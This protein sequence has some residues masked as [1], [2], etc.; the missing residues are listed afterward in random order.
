MRTLSERLGP[1]PKVTQR[2]SIGTTTNP[3]GSGPEPVPGPVPWQRSGCSGGCRIREV[4]AAPG[5]K[6]TYPPIPRPAPAPSILTPT[7]IPS[8]RTIKS[9]F[10]REREPL[11][12]TVL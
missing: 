9:A 10:R 12:H 4:A 5:K 8:P 2:A 6:R 11:P 3:G 1:L 7:P